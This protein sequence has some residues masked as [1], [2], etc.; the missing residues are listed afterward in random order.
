[1]DPNVEMNRYDNTTVPFSLTQSSGLADFEIAIGRYLEITLSENV[2]N[3]TGDIIDEASIR[4]YYK[5]SD[6]DRTGDGIADDAE[7]IDETT[8]AMY[9]FNESSS[10]WTKLSADLDWV[11]EIGVDTEDI[12]LY[13]NSY[14]GYV[15][16]SVSHLSLFG[17]AGQ[18]SVEPIEADVHIVPRTINRNNHLKSIMAIMSV[19]KGISRGDIADGQFELYAGGLDGEPIEAISHRVNGKGKKAKVF[20]K[21]NKDELMN[22]VSHNGRVELTVVIRLESGQ[23]IYGS[24]TVKIIKKKW[25]P[26]W[27]WF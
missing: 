3:Q 17:L 9:Y 22:A 23:Y 16:A 18:P 12:E 2:Q 21:F 7:D 19:P 15:W 14:A 25:R 1:M 26:S 6:L 5:E 11:S 4:I 10:Q 13:G 20:V 27:K 24:D 8:L